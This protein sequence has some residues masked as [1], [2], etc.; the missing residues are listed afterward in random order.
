MTRE[1]KEKEFRKSIE[2]EVKFK[3]KEVYKE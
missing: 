1:D 2:S 3:C